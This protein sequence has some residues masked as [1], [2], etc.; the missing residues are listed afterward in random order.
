MKILAK[1]R[2]FGSAGRMVDAVREIGDRHVGETWLTRRRWSLYNNALLLAPTT[3]S[4]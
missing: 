2:G 1:Q 3:I 4:T